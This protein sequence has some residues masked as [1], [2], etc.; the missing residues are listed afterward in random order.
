MM[1]AKSPTHLTVDGTI[2]VPATYRGLQAKLDIILVSRDYWP[3]YEEYGGFVSGEVPSSP[4]SR[5]P[6]RAFSVGYVL[7]GEVPSI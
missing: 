7:S 2:Y 3:I 6:I 4:S 5:Q 1:H